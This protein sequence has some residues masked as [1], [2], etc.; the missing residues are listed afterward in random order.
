MFHLKTINDHVNWSPSLA[1][2][3]D[4]GAVNAKSVPMLTQDVRNSLYDVIIHVG[5]FAYDMD[6]VITF[7]LIKTLFNISFH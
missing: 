5:D 7:H 1:V 2:Y 3:G 4:M 6:K